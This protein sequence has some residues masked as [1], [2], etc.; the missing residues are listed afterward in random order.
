MAVSVACL[1]EH[2]KGV[3][4]SLFRLL[5]ELRDLAG[6]DDAI[7][8]TIR[9][10]DH[11]WAPLGLLVEDTPAADRLVLRSLR[12]QQLRERAQNLALPPGWEAT[13]ENRPPS[14]WENLPPAPKAALPDPGNW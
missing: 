6:I 12:N 5:L 2:V 4:G 7:I 13:A 8:T 9:L 1:K 10:E 11:R 3:Q 14:T